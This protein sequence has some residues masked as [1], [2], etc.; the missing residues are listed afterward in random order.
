MQLLE[1]EQP[2]EAAIRREKEALEL[3]VAAKGTLD[4]EK[5]LVN[6]TWDPCYKI[7]SPKLFEGVKFDC[8]TPDSIFL[9]SYFSPANCCLC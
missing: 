4:P 9:I 6:A 5:V 7:S 1:P 3:V 2:S 8:L